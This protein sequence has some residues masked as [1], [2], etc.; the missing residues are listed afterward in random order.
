MITLDE[1]TY[2][3]KQKNILHTTSLDFHLNQN[4]IILGPNGAGKS[5]LLRIAAGGIVPTSGKIYR[6]GMKNPYDSN[7]LARKR[8]FLGQSMEVSVEFTV[9]DLVMMGRYP[10][11]HRIPSKMDQLITDHVIDK[12][13]LYQFES[14]KL[15]QLSGGELQRAHVARVYAQLFTNQ[16]EK[17]LEGKFIFMDEPVN[18]LDIKHQQQL[19]K[20]SQELVQKGVGV[21]A[22]LHDINMALGF[23][24][25][26]LFVKNGRLI[27]DFSD[28]LKISTDILEEVYEIPFQQTSEH[29]FFPKAEVETMLYQV[30]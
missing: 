16:D 8:A 29:Y 21:V 11:Y 5:T 6:Q 17:S 22:V 30:I 10:H 28:T 23:A 15:T 2:R 14:R 26:I 12:F 27:A 1:V 20:L 9:R 25:R 18:N 24:N 7:E 13:N 3:V 19:M 4:T